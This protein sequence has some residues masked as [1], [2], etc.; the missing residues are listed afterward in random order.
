MILTSSTQFVA[1]RRDKNFR[2][3]KKT[4]QKKIYIKISLIGS[5][6][7]VYKTQGKEKFPLV[8]QQRVHCEN[9]KVNKDV[10]ISYLRKDIRYS[11]FHSSEKNRCAHRAKISLNLV[12]KVYDISD[13][14]CC[15]CCICKDGWMEARR[16]TNRNYVI[17]PNS[18][19]LCKFLILRNSRYGRLMKKLYTQLLDACNEEGFLWSNF[20]PSTSFN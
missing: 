3:K 9:E 12:I 18:W 19:W 10:K 20:F 17:G 5:N 4:A 13:I 7:W 11:S 14:F 8:S 16:K 2:M 15:C 1:M 6:I